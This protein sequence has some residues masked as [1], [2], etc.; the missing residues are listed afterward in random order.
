MTMTACGNSAPLKAGTPASKATENQLASAIKILAGMLAVIREPQPE[1]TIVTAATSP[2]R[3][4]LGLEGECVTPVGHDLSYQYCIHGD[5]SHRPW[6]HK[7]RSG[8]RKP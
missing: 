8:V 4:A 7:I 3:L 5:F 2:K 6:V 1:R